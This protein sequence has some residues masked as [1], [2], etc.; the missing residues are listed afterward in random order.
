MTRDLRMLFGSND[1]ELSTDEAFTDRQAQWAHVTAALTEHLRQVSAPGFDVEDLEAPRRN[2]LHFHGVGGIGKSTLSRKIEAALAGSGRP[3]HWPEAGPPGVR[4]VPV[5]IDLARSAGM[6][7]EQIVLTLRL[8][9]TRIGRPLPAFDVALRRY[10]ETVHPG[11]P[12]EEYLKR[13]G[14]ARTF[15]QALPQQMKSA[16]ADVAQA[17]LLPGTIG[18]VVGEVVGSLVTALRERRQTVRALSGCRRLADLLEA[19]PDLDALSYYPHLLAWEIARLPGERVVPVVL[20]DTFEDT[21]DRTRRE[22]ERLLQRVVWLMPNAL[23]VLTGRSRLEWAEDALAGQLDH[24]G[25][26]AWPDLADPATVVPAPRIAGSP[27]VPERQVLIGDFSPEDC[28][29]YLARRLTRNSRPLI[30]AALRQ[31][32]SDRSHGLPLYL[33]LAVMRVLQL[34]RTGRTPTPADFDADFPALISRTLQD[35]TPDERHVLRSATLFDSFDIPLATKASGLAHEAAALRLTERPFIRHHPFGLWP[36]HLHALIRSTLRTADDPTDDRWSPTDWQHAAE[37]AFAALGDQW[38]TDT[39]DRLLLVGCLRQGLALARD[40]RLSPGWL[41]DAAFAY[42]GDSVWEPI[43]L[44]APITTGPEGP[45]R[46]EG[47]GAA[48][49]ADLVVD[50]LSTLARRQREHRGHTVDK[51]TRLIDSG[52]LGDD[53]TVMAVYYRAKAR[54]DIGH[55]EASRRDYQHVADHGGRLAAAARRGLAKAAHLAGDFPTAHTAAQQL[56]WEGRHQRVLGGLYWLQGEPE[57][58][59]AAYLAGRTEA[60]EHAVRGEAAHNQAK[61]A[62]A[63]AFTDPHLADDEL[64]LAYHLLTGLD[65]RATTINTEIAALV[66]DAGH[67]TVDDRVRTLRAELDIAGLISKLPTL[68][69]AA[70]FHQAVLDDDQALSGTLGRLRE[71]TRGGMHTYAIDIVH[72]MAGLPLPDGHAP[73]RWLDDEQTTRSRWRGLVIRR[74]NLLRTRRSTSG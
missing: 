32:I 51:L 5:R 33:D 19:E 30:D 52:L 48:T 13:G 61:R 21:G 37:R 49:P 22:M 60:E 53:L 8:A 35:L 41:T 38:H 18:T 57:R 70:A 10:W 58:A 14:L 73:A 7:F 46:S 65:L 12:L 29:G 9:L 54:R 3:A 42:V 17:L 44:S 16:L 4:V 6:D 28:D 27:R 67:D 59:A 55:P 34:H 39:R 66:R 24:T 11:E 45:E 63:I 62:L 26:A 68:E 2:V 43:T 69:I 50:L 31:V 20:F 47:M 71:Q 1:Q 56:G 72:F 36:Y 64:D 40:F 25:P 74:Q 23:F 15:G